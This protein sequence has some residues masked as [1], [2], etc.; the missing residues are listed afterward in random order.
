[1]L[2]Q[3]SGTGNRLFY[4]GRAAFLCCLA[5][6]LALDDNASCWRLALE[7]ARGRGQVPSAPDADGEEVLV[8]QAHDFTGVHRRGR[9]KGEPGPGT[10][11]PLVLTPLTLASSPLAQPSDSPPLRSPSALH[12]LVSPLRC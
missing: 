6:L 4:P 9:R 5:L 10:P 2:T 11:T 1:M 3:P 8:K 7:G 12:A